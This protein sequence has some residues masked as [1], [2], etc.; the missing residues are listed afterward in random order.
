MYPR[1]LIA[2][3]PNSSTEQGIMMSSAVF[4]N[5]ELSHKTIYDKAKKKL[6]DVVEIRKVC[7]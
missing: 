1:T 2:A 6:S 3:T 7:L 4:E 5:E